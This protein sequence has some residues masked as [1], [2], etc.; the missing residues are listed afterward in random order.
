M[1]AKDLSSIIQQL[2]DDIIR[3]ATD[4]LPRKV[5]VTAVNHFRQNFRDAGFR[6]SGLKPWQK[7]KRQQGKGTDA[8]YTPLTSRRNHLMRST[9]FTTTPGT[10]TIENTVPYASIHNEGG[11]INT[12]PRVTERLRRYAWHMAYAIAGIRGKGTLPKELPREA[13]KWRAM[14]LT[15]KQRLNV[16]AHIPKRQF[17]GESKELADKINNIINL[18]LQR[19]KNGI[20]ALTS[21]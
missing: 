20:S 5:G 14:A 2:K 6:D 12:H 17:I 18:S 7:T 8:A 10:V 4:R 15:K 21:R 13:A 3:E 19:I 9:S 16:R 1:D 11:D